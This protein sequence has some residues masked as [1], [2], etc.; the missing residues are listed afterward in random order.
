V[1]NKAAI[2]A[3]ARAL[4]DFLSGDDPLYAADAAITAYRAYLEREGMVVVPRGMAEATTSAAKAVDVRE[5][6]Q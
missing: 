1:T 6:S 4:G 3:V 2:E 5:Q